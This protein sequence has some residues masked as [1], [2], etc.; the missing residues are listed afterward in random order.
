MLLNRRGFATAVFCRQCGA[1][2]ECPNCSVSL[3]VHQRGAPRALPLLQLL[4]A[5]AEGRARSAPAST[6]SRS[7]SAPSAS[8]P[9]VR[10]AFPDAR[11]ARVDRDTIRRRGAIAALL[12][13]SR[14]GE[15]D[16]LVG[17]Q[18]IAKGH[19][20]P[21]VTLVGVISA[22]VGLGL[23][24]FRAA[25]RTFQLLTQVAGP[26]RARRDPRRGDRPDALS[27][28]LQHPHA[29]RQDYAGFFARGDCSSGRRCGIRRRCALINAVVKGA[30]VQGAM[31]R[32]RRARQALRRG[33]APSGSSGRRR[34]RSSRLKGEHRVAVLPEGHATAAA[35]RQAL[36]AALPRAPRHR[37]P[38]D[39]RCRIRSR[40]CC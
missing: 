18:M 21:R 23:A 33:G 13:G 26:R 29:C 35:M 34:R 6:S 10:D 20:F 19:D 30:H 1:T 24:D 3:T 16:V 15:I 17:T 36:L 2:L 38:D 32:R 7:A 11:V 8:R 4:D 5:A 22:D 25:E 14:A 9:R 40:A 31:A 28:P 39:G 27:R 37:A 12:A